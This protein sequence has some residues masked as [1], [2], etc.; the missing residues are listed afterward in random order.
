[1]A[2]IQLNKNKIIGDYL[3]PYIVAELNTSHFG[4]MDIAKEMIDRAKECGCDCVKLQ[5]W[6]ADSLYSKKYYEDNKMAKRFFDKFS[7]EPNQ[8][9]ELSKFSESIEIDLTSTPYSIEEAEFLANEINVPFI[10]IAS[11]EI[12]NYRY[13]SQLGNLQKPLVLSTGM[14]TIQEIENAL[15]IIEKTDNKK[16]IIL[17]CVSIY[18]SVPEIINLQN[19]VGLRNS[20]PNYPIGFS[21]HTIGINIPTASVALGAALIEKHFTL[22]NEKIG[23]DNQMATEPEAMKNMIDSCKNVYLSMGSKKREVNTEELEQ[24]IKMRR[25]LISQ[26][27]LKKGHI[28]S[29]EDILMKRPGDGIP[30]NEINKII[31][32]KLLED[33]DEE[34]QFKLEKIDPNLRQTKS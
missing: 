33:I 26:R 9:L 1:M 3:N 21:D 25:S 11:M 30:P 10:K 4:D 23:F 19:I 20:F 15:N 16:I 13:L 7:L 28:I 14:A 34:T 24:R 18:P 31:G 8:I 12:N 2:E 5:S 22:N 27:S 6:S 32:C 29:E 17:H